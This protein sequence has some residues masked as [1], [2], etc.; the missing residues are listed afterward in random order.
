[1]KSAKYIL[2]ISAALCSI[3]IVYYLKANDNN[4]SNITLM[5]KEISLS[6][7]EQG[8]E[9]LRDIAVSLDNK[10]VAYIQSDHT[11]GWAVV[12]GTPGEKYDCN[13]FSLLGCAFSPDSKHLAYVAGTKEKKNFVVLDSEEGPGGFSGIDYP[14]FSPD[15]RQL[16]Y[17]AWDNGLKKEVVLLN[18]K[19]LGEYSRIMSLVF[20]SDGKRFG[21]AAGNG[22]NELAV[23]D[24]KEGQYYDYVGGFM[25]SRDCQHYMYNASRG[26]KM[27]IVKDDIEINDSNGL[28]SAV[29]NPDLNRTAC[30]YK[31][32]DKKYVVVDENK[33][34]L[35]DEITGLKFSPDGRHYVYAA[36]TDLGPDRTV[37]VVSDGQEQKE[38]QW[39]K[40]IIFSPNSEH[41]AYSA[42]IKRKKERCIVVDVNEGKKYVL[43]LTKPNF[44]VSPPVFSPDS[45]HVGYVV[46]MGNQ[47]WMVVDEVE[48]RHYNKIRKE[49]PDGL[50][51]K[52]DKS[53]TFVV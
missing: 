24:G 38:Y 30:I 9:Y 14:T 47:S 8:L 19:K 36:W 46:E 37:H 27:I 53:F 40:D 21:F 23:I 42:G 35:Y 33:G 16:A 6:K 12:N 15:N 1:M 41:I 49:S 48:G 26:N 31:E 52:Y 25:F 22:N 50:N 44:N 43:E 29:F 3:Y 17:R 2:I 20:S 28:I 18:G 5:T 4:P 45:K 13:F 10:R 51:S 11:Y 39:A 7:Y 34:K 32:G